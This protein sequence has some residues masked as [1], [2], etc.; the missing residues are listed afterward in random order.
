MTVPIQVSFEHID[1]SDFIEARV[2]EEAEKL[3]RY[4]DRISFVRAVIVRP[5]HRQHKG[6]VYGV[7]LQLSIP[8]AED[9]VIDRES[10]ATG[11]HEDMNVAIRDAFDAARRKLEDLSRRRQDRERGHI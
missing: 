7:R 8:G 1:R 11:R 4:Y 9:I 3:E 6:D 10:A 5:Q 2:R